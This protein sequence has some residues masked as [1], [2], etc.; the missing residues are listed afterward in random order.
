MELTRR[1]VF[2]GHAA[3]Y[4]GR[5][6]RPK[7]DVIIT[8]AASSLTVVGG[9]S[10]SEARGKKFGN[11]FI[12][13]GSASTSAQ[14]AF[15]DTKQAIALTWGKVKEEE[16]TTTTKVGASTERIVIGAKP[17]P[18]LSVGRLGG[19]LTSYSGS[20]REELSIKLG[21]DAVIDGVEIDGYPLKITLNKQVFDQFDTL[22][23]LEAAGTDP[24]FIKATNDCL[25]RGPNAPRMPESPT[26]RAPDTIYA[27]IVNEVRWAKK[28]HP[29][30]KI[31]HHTVM[32]PDWGTVFFG[33]ALITSN[34][35]RVTMLRA[36]LG[37]PTGGDFA[38]SEY[39]TNGSWYPPS[40]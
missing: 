22:S 13:I 33:E 17:F 19:S 10:T 14:G 11:G 30:A 9:V 15:T 37:S 7:N 4:G 2:R 39:E 24:E 36:R 6:Y 31:D 1:F 5:I 32:I 8:G 20:P 12:S 3:S 40:I 27:T 26:G 18:R 28:E 35:R 29:T 21:R 34:S 25:F 16:L 38:A 23:K